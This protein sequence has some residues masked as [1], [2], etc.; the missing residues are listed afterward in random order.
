MGH[1]SANMAPLG[2]KLAESKSCESQLSGKLRV[3]SESVGL[4]LVELES[5]QSQLSD[6]ASSTPNGAI[7]AESWPI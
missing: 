4:K 2:L 3:S 1:N 5:Y 7:L 6:S